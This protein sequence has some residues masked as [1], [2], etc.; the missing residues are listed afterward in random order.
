M[1]IWEEKLCFCV[2]SRKFASAHKTF[3]ME[4]IIKENAVLQIFPILDQPPGVSTRN[5]R[6]KQSTPDRRTKDRHK[7][8]SGVKSTQ[9][10]TDNQVSRR[11]QGGAD[12]RSQGGSGRSEVLAQDQGGS[13]GSGIL[14]EGQGGSVGLAGQAA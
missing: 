14:A 10:K 4:I 8:G 7:A 5:T 1:V 11:D 12:G 6:Q 9:A 2:L 3:V 13:G